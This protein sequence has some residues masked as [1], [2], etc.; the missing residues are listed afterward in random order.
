MTNTSNEAI[1]A[2]AIVQIIITLLCI[3]QTHVDYINHV[4]CFT[5]QR[6]TKHRS[7]FNLANH[8]NYAKHY[9][10]TTCFTILC[11]PYM[12]LMLNNLRKQSKHMIHTKL[13]CLSYKH[14]KDITPIATKQTSITI[15]TLLMK[16]TIENIE[17]LR[18]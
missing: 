16:H 8:K 12:Y 1:K 10:N 5:L 13:C 11:I 3:I 2:I 18:S 4:K 17:P 14:T 9:T 7:L 6:F 15:I